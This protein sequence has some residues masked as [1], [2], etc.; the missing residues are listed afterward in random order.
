MW[1]ETV[2]AYYEVYHNIILKEL[3]KTVKLEVRVVSVLLRLK[4]GTSEA[5]LLE[6]THSASC[7]DV[8]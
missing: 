1:S 6:T 4:L 2:L 5:Q 3:K 7:V 8:R